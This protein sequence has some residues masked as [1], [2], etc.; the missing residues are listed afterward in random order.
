MALGMA[1]PQKLPRTGVYLFRRRV[2]DRLRTMVGKT[3]EVRSRR[4]KDPEVARARFL[5]I[6]A[7]V[8]ERWKNLPRDPV[9]L[10]H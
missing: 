4:T 9:A 3:E 7:E 10:T 2:P 8:E 6:A 1:R 5:A